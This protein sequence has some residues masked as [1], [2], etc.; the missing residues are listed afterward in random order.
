[1]GNRVPCCR[2]R[3]DLTT[4]LRHLYTAHNHRG[5]TRWKGGRYSRRH[6]VRTP[7]R[8][9]HSLKVRGIKIRIEGPSTDPS[10]GANH[11]LDALHIFRPLKLYS[12]H[13]HQSVGADLCIHHF[14]APQTQLSDQPNQCRFGCVGGTRKHAFSRKQF[15]QSHPI[16]TTDQ[17]VPSPDFD[18]VGVASSCSRQWAHASPW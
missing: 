12:A 1:M 3:W 10:L 2:R 8:P 5:W 18:R 13:A 7:A 6:D 14:K 16:Q 15:P 9:R 4:H 11:W 17:C